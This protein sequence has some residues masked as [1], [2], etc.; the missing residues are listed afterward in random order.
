[1]H[2]FANKDFGCSLIRD[3]QTLRKERRMS[4]VSFVFS[5]GGARG[6]LQVGAMRA[7]TEA[8]ILPDHM[9]GVSIGAANAAY[10][11]INGVS[12]QSIDRLADL[13]IAGTRHDPLP[14]NPFRIALSALIHSSDDQFY[15]RLRESFISFGLNPA[16][17][18]KDLTDIQLTIVASDLNT[19]TPILFGNIPGA[20]D[21]DLILDAVL[22]SASIPPWIK[23]RERNGRLLADGGVV[24]GLPIEPAI[25]QGSTEIYALD[26]RELREPQEGEHG[27]MSLMDKLMFSVFSREKELEL[28][29]AATQGIQVR[30]IPLVPPEPVGISDFHHTRELIEQGYSITRRTIQTWQT[31]KELTYDPYR[32]ESP[33]LELEPYAYQPKPVR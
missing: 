8:G 15:E 11:A 31:E 21:D 4:R 17:S 18:F 22:A 20:Y 32:G 10:L 12:L 30:M 5:G 25:S 27:W 1:M 19:G 26:L 14:T 28:A 33:A 16:L 29:L 2:R 24:S 3:P 13:W 7:L 6:A 9:V 23:P